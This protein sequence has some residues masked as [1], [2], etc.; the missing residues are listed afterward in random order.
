M[1]IGEGMEE[2]RFF[3]A[4]LAHLGRTD[5]QVEQY[6]GKG[7]LSRFLEALPS[8]PGYSRLVALGIT[9]D[10]DESATDA[11]K[12]VHDALRRAKLEPPGNRIKR[13]RIH[14]F[15]LPGDAAPGMLEDLCLRS[16]RDDPAMPCV[17]QFLHCVS[18]RA[19][20]FPFKEAKAR[21]HAWL[22]S[23]PVPDKRLGEAAEAG[24]WR[25]DHPAF[26]GLKSFV[27]SL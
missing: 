5:V 18:Q 11:K 15:I 8:V 20:R 2:K 10:A 14:V 23:Q 7:G 4:L 24:Y 12:S 1:L 3:A 17:D 6:G 26:D 19:G 9:R 22:S 21:V 27:G 16:V 25:F 13:L